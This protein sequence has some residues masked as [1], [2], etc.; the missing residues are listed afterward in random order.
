MSY[1]APFE[2]TFVIQRTKAVAK[3][4][5]YRDVNFAKDTAFVAF[6]AKITRLQKV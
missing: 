3:G 5:E 1:N 2:L 4:F 6:S